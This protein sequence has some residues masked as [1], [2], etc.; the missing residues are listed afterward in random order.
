MAKTIAAG[1]VLKVGAVVVG[2]VS[3][4]SSPNPVKSE[5]DVTDFASTAA[6]FLM[7]LADYGEISFSGDFNYADAGQLVIMGDAYDTSSAARSFVLEF[8][9][10]AMKFT[11]NAWVRSFVVNASGASDAYRFDCALRITGAV[12]RAALP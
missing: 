6:Q 5:V 10:Q 8:T 2:S 7:G 11:F 3:T 1:T 9:T 4:I 12:T